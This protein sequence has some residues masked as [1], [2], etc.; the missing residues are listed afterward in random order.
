MLLRFGTLLTAF[1]GA[2]AISAIGA[3]SALAGQGDKN[4]AMDYVP[5]A[6]KGTALGVATL[7]SASKIPSVQLPDISSIYA[8]LGKTNTFTHRQNI[9]GGLVLGSPAVNSM[10]PG[11]IRGLVPMSY[12]DNDGDNIAYN[13]QSIIFGDWTLDSGIDPGFVWGTNFYTATGTTPGSANGVTNLYGGLIEAD[14][15]APAGSHLGIVIGLQAEASF[16][17]PASG[18]M[19]DEMRSLLVAAPVRKDGAIAGTAARSYG[20][21][22]QAVT[23][24]AVGATQ[25]YS[26]FV[27]GGLT[28]L[29]GPTRISPS[30]ASDVGLIIRQAPSTTVDALRITDTF[31]NVNARI[32]Q[33]GQIATSNNHLAYEGQLGQTVIGRIGPS[34]GAGKEPGISMGT[35]GDAKL[36]RSATATLAVASGTRLDGV[37]G[38][39]LASQ[40]YNPAVLT[41][42]TTTSTN[43]T[44]VDSKN[45]AITFTAPLS[46]KVAVR[47]SALIRNQT[48][49]QTVK[50]NVR[51][52]GADVTGSGQSI[53]QESVAGR[54]QFVTDVVGLTPGTSI[55]LT[56]GWRV[57]GGVGEITVGG[58]DVGPLRID[59][60]AG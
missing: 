15:R 45:A 57:V 52:G 19:V 40:S 3:D 38:V 7:D 60:E 36:Y 16:A 18:A 10:P 24:S 23:A 54:R 25:A 49:G 29:N 1:T 50:F 13:F 34:S 8:G 6:E 33:F 59:V 20:L 5:T 35:F 27:A 2:T 56:L 32:D 21:Y 4:P 47:V 46:G 12:T 30:I 14:V 55:T 42:L 17:H 9:P 48:A 53:T 44:D 22:V 39:T 26:V 31:G 43:F 58:T 11:A 51:N 37:P 41:T 28:Q